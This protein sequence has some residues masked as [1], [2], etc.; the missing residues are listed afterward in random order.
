MAEAYFRFYAELNDFLPRHKRHKTFP[1]EFAGHETVKHILEAVGVPHTEVDLILIN[2]ESVGFDHA[3]QPGDR[4]SVYP[5]FEILDISKLTE[6]RPEPLREPK[7]VLDNHLGKLAG[8]L[9]LLGFDTRY[10]NH[11]EDPELA[12]ISSE[13]DRILLTR[14]RGLLK[15]KQVTHGYCVRA[16]DPKEQIIEV[17]RKFDIADFVKPYTRCARCNGLLKPVPK[18]EVLEQLEP[19]TKKYYD[20]FMQCQDCQQVY[21]KGSHFQEL[22]EFLSQVVEEAQQ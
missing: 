16:D 1:V 15:R 8:Y 7:F 20:H 19:L 18:R 21:W 12:S 14:D 10:E 5:M 13:D 11:Y 3:V 17:L 4:V 6:V 9:R 2:G 22:N